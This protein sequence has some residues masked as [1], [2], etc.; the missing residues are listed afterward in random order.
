MSTS[1]LK[2]VAAKFKAL[3]GH[4]NSIIKKF[5]LNDVLI[6]DAN[7]LLIKIQL[8]FDNDENEAA[9]VQLSVLALKLQQ[10]TKNYS[11]IE[12]LRQMSRGRPPVQLELYNSEQSF[13]DMFK[14]PDET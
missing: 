4:L 7:K 5:E 11:M 10:I 12:T 8:H 9:N 13:E 14:G 2:T 3:E 6:D 1:E